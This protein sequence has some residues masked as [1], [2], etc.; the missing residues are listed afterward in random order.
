MAN[1]EAGVRAD[2]VT[3]K[4]RTAPLSTAS[5]GAPVTMPGFFSS[6]PGSREERKPPFPEGSLK[7][8]SKPSSPPSF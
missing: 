8:R 7:L 3:S 2:T 6:T 5:I 4:Y 1:L